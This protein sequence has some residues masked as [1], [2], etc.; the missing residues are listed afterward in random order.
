MMAGNIIIH[1][2]KG[3]LITTMRDYGYKVKDYTNLNKVAEEVLSIQNNEI[4]IP[5]MEERMNYIELT[6]SLNKRYEDFRML[7]L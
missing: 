7:G 2:G 3:G 6:F 5:I 4:L 1:S